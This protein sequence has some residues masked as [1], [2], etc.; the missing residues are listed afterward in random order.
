VTVSDKS[1]INTVT[2]TE[3]WIFKFKYQL[4]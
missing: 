1:Y 4:Q 2:V 3:F